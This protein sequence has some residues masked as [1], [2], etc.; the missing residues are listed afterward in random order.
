MEYTYPIDVDWTQEDILKVVHFFNMIEAYYEKS[1]ISREI[2]MDAYKDF[3]SVVPGKAD[4]KNI[5]ETFKKRSGY[6]SYDVVK[7]AK[8]QR[9]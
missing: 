8:D 4:E 7:K 5:F 2:L 9:L 6:D 3:K 1:T